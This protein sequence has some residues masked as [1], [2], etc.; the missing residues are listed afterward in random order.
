VEFRL[1]KID[2]DLRQLVNDKTKEGK[3]HSKDEVLINKDSSYEKREGHNNRD[4]RPKEKFSLEKYSGKTKKIVVE[5]EKTENIE[6]EA[7]KETG[8]ASDN[9]YMGRF[10]D[11]RK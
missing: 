1:N 11:I 3:V 9:T 4:R 10:I 7:S 5:A 8:H 6:V 2:T